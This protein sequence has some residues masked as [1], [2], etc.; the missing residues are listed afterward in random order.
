MSSLSHRSRAGNLRADMKQPKIIR[1]ENWLRIRR[2]P[3]R[4]RRAAIAAECSR[5][6]PKMTKLQ[7]FSCQR[8]NVLIHAEEIF[9]IILRLD[10][11]QSTIVWAICSRHRL[12]RLVIPQI[13]HIASRRKERC[14]FWNVLLVHA[15]HRSLSVSFS[16]SHNMRKL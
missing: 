8:S 7:F 15:M 2:T 11:L 1:S 16:H 5:M 13:V 10:L 12:T 6:P 4:P 14:I 3:S 9:G